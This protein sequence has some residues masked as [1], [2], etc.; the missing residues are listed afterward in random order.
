[1]RASALLATAPMREMRSSRS[2]TAKAIAAVVNYTGVQLIF[3]AFHTE[4]A[5][6]L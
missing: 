2:G 4:A 6:H 1:M 3:S 5:S